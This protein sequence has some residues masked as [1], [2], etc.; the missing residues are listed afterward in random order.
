M[1]L[2]DLRGGLRGR[3]A[4]QPGIK[5]APRNPMQHRYRSAEAGRELMGLT[6]E[7]GGDEGKKLTSGLHDQTSRANLPA[8]MRSNMAN[9]SRTSVRDVGNWKPNILTMYVPP[10]SSNSKAAAVSQATSF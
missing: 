9:R 5:G 6:A 1:L 8:T 10:N 4:L 2:F 3:G 7:I